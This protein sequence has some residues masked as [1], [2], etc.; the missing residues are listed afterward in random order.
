MIKS[1]SFYSYKLNSEKLEFIKSY[2][3]EYD[4]NKINW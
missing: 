1:Y 3:I 4:L 2:I